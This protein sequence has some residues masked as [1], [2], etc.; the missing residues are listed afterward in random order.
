MQLQ[1]YKLFVILY[2]ISFFNAFSQNNLV[3]ILDVNSNIALEMPY[4]TPNNFMNKIVYAC[5][6][7]LLQPEVAKALVEANS[8]FNTKGYRIKIYDCYRPIDV[9]KKMWKLVPRA[10]YVANPENGGS[11]HNRGAAVD[12][13]L[14]SLDNSYVDM[15]TSFDFFGKKA[16]IDNLD[17]P[18]EILENRKL[19]FE[20]MRKFGFQTIRTEWWHFSYK[21]KTIFPLL[22]DPLPCEN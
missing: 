13:T 5:E 22:N 2:I 16:H 18:E 3:N 12:L 1:W 17:L 15:G 19:L 6:I 21:K 4:A 10:T 7:C 14:V 11:I 9:Q 20:G 8:Y